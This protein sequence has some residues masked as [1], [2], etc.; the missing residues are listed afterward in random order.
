M[1]MN[2]TLTATIKVTLPN[3]KEK[4]LYDRFDCYQTPTEVTRSILKATDRTQAYLQ[5]LGDSDTSYHKDELDNWLEYHKNEGW[6]IKWGE[7]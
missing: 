7:M 2:I 3:G 6:C 4:M 1:S 5:W